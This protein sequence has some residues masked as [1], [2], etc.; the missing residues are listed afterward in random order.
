MKKMFLLI[1][2]S[3]AFNFLLI[4]CDPGKDCGESCKEDDDCNISRLI[5]S[6]GGY[7]VPTECRDC[8]N[9]GEACY[10]T[11]PENGTCDFKYCGY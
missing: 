4:S 5:C 10:T 6:P 1:C 9:N 8:Y 3:V 2:V 7:C 11:E